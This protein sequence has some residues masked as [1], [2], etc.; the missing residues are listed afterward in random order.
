MNAAEIKALLQA[1]GLTPNRALGQNFLVDE[2]AAAAIAEASGAAEF[3]VLEIGPGLGALT[4]ELLRRSSQVVA[5]EIDA[6]MVSILKERLH[7]KHQRH[8]VLQIPYK[9]LFRTYHQH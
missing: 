6:A 9:H 3:P 4:E 5:V 2:A 1:H 8:G 7:K